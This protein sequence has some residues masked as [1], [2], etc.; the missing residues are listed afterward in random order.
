VW[1]VFEGVSEL[2]ACG[3]GGVDGGCLREFG[4]G[5]WPLGFEIGGFMEGLRSSVYIGSSKGVG[6]SGLGILYTGA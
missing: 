2:G 5:H 4:I 3:V 6:G 1:G